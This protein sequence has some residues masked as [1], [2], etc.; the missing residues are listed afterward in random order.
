MH[1]WSGWLLAGVLLLGAGCNAP[2]DTSPPAA[3][4]GPAAPVEISIQN[5]SSVDFDSVVVA[6]PSQR[7]NFGPVAAG[8]ESSYRTVEM[9]YRYAYV[10]AHHAGA[11]PYV[12]QPIDY[13]GEELLA[14]G[15]YSYALDIQN[16]EL[17]LELITR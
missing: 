2:S 6:F 10:E 7:E 8:A 11:E 13:T 5:D 12:L 16:G 3:P 15:R 14:D 4:R 1:F 9:A 17:T